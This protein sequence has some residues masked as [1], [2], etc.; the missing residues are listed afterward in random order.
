MTRSDPT[1]VRRRR[2]LETLGVLST[3]GIAGL[4]GCGSDGDGT[5]QDGGDTVPSGDYPVVEQWLTEEEVGGADESWDGSIVDARARTDVT[6]EVGAQGNGDSLAFDPSAVAVAPGTTV[7]WQW[8]GEGGQHNVV[9]SPDD[10]IGESDFEFSSGDSVEGSDNE[11]ATALEGTG[12]ALYQCEPHVS[13]GMKGAV[14]VAESAG[15][16]GTG[17]GGDATGTTTGG[18]A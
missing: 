7:T 18:G 8:T 12:V 6:V 5:V 15:G 13:V 10:G 1:D 17:G 11:F 2:V 3:A 16:T 4:A 14:V 9:A